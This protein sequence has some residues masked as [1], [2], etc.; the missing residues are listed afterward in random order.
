MI[1]KKIIVVAMGLCLLF[2]GCGKKEGHITGKTMGTTYHIK[3][4][5]KFLVN[6]NKLGLKI[7]KRLAE[8]EASMSAFLETS[9]L[10]RFNAFDKKVELF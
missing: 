1:Q 8:I 4:T 10:S 7:D 6:I 3:A 5:I 2:L 9:E